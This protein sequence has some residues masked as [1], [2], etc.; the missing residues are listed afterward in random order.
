MAKY[1][2]KWEKLKEAAKKKRSGSTNLPSTAA[3][4]MSIS[5]VQTH[6]D[7]N[8]TISSQQSSASTAD[9]HTEFRS[10]IDQHGIVD[11][12]KS[13]LDEAERS[14]E[15]DVEG[16]NERKESAADSVQDLRASSSALTSSLI[17]T[18]KARHRP[19]PTSVSTSSENVA[20]VDL[21]DVDP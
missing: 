18:P 8:R 7:T 17:A 9:H 11:F 15:V 6:T 12:E 3:S 13:T 21:N 16:E 10:K 1:R 4:S 2:G 20:E 14:E 5:A 19:F